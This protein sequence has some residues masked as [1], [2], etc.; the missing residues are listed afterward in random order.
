MLS[1]QQLCEKYSNH[2]FKHHTLQDCK[3]RVKLKSL[4]VFVQ[5]FF[6]KKKRKK[7]SE[8]IKFFDSLLTWIFRSPF[9]ISLELVQIIYARTTKADLSYVVCY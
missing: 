6:E 9:A 8:K 4:S 3:S 2:S 1:T 7:P 5:F